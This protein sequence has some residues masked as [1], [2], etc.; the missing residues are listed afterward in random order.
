MKPPIV[1]DDNGD[2]EVC[3]SITDAEMQLEPY[4]VGRQG[5]RIFDSDGVILET[6]TEVDKRS[7][8]GVERFRIREPKNRII[9]DAELRESIVSFLTQTG[10]AVVDFKADFKEA[11][12]G[13]L[14]SLLPVSDPHAPLPHSTRWM[15]IGCGTALLLLIFLCVWFVRVQW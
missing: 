7:W 5:L 8:F 6:F 1:I 3:R 14:I 4:D 15:L 9:R 13:E 2:L 10:H 12:L 11:G